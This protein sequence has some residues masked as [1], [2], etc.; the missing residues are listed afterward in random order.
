MKLTGTHLT[1]QTY[2]MITYM[3]AT[4]NIADESVTGKAKKSKNSISRESTL[5]KVIYSFFNR[6]IGAKQL[7]S[8]PVRLCYIQ[9]LFFLLQTYFGIKFYSACY[10]FLDIL[11]LYDYTKLQGAYHDE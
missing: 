7:P 3:Q 9:F 5:Q 11:I 1:Q 10:Y 6:C 2:A 4:Q 8:F